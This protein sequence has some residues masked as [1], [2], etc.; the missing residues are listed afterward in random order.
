MKY[1]ILALRVLLGLTFV[2]FG[3]NHFLKFI[4][5]ENPSLPPAAAN[6]ASALGSSGYLNAVKVFE[7]SGGVLLVTGILVPLGLVLLTPVLVNIVC[8]D[9]FLMQKPGLGMFLLAVA[10]YLIW[11]YRPYFQALFTVHAQPVVKGK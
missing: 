7:I 1:A 11:A 2:V 9:V 5:M 4:P 3:L 8:F 10:I 6:F